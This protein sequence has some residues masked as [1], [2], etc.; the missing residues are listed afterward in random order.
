MSKWTAL[1]ASRRF[2]V[3]ALAIAILAIAGD[4]LDN[5]LRQALMA[6][7]AAWTVSQGLRPTPGKEP[8]Q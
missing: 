3:T 7:V 2:W 6:L 8:P 4:T 1:F 5:N